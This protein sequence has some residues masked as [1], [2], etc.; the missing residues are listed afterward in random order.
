MIKEANKDSWVAVWDRNDY[1][2]EAGR[3]LSD[4]K[5][6]KDISNMEN[7]LSK[8]LETSKRMFNSLKSR[9]FLTKKQMKYFTYD[10]KKGTNFGKLYLLPKLHKRFHDVPGRLVIS[11]CGTP[12][13]KCSFSRKKSFLTII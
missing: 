13:E 8:L 2:Q 11:N 10:F 4:A 3:Q 12:R 9:G 6:Y 1:L 7:I 5:V